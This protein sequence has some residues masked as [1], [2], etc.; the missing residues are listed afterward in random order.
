MLSTENTTP[1]KSSKPRNSNSSVQ[2]QIEPK[3][4]FEFI[5]RDTEKSEFLD[6]V[7][8][9]DYVFIANCNSF[10][11]GITHAQTQTQAHTNTQKNVHTHTHTYT[12]TQTLTHTPAPTH[13]HTHTS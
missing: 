6:L 8:F 7:D 2:I 12:H 9:G 13:P 3:S 4:R 5:P 1:P 11:V 10:G